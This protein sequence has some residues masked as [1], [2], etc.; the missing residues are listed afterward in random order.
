VKPDGAGC[1]GDDRR[2]GLDELGVGVG[3]RLAGGRLEGR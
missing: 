1:F 2:L 3:G